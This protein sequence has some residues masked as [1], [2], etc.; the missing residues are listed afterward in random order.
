M[1]QHWNYQNLCKLFI[2]SLE[3]LKS[4]ISVIFAYL[5]PGSFDLQRCEARMT[6]I[7]L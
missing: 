7:C 1:F 6:A 5:A 2:S 4:V 3:A